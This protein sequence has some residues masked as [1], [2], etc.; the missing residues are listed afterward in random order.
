[1]FEIQELALTEVSAN[2]ELSAMTAN[3]VNEYNRADSLD[4]STPNKVSTIRPVISGI[5]ASNAV[6]NAII[7]EVKTIFNL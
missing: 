5:D 4:R 7:S 1:L 3:N 2:N 6:E